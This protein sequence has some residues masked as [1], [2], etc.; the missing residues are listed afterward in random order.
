MSVLLTFIVSRAILVRMVAFE[1][2]QHLGLT[3]KE[4]SAYLA[5][6]EIGEGTVAAVA[7][8]SLLKRPTAYLILD[9]LSEKGFVSQFKRGKHTYYI[10]QNPKYL[11]SEAEM[12]LKEIREAIPQLETLFVKGKNKPRVLI[13]EGKEGADKAYDDWFITK[14][15]ALFLSSAELAQE[16]FEKT[17]RRVDF[18]T[19]SD[20][21]Y[22]RELILDTPEGREY[23]E[24]VRGQYRKVRFLPPEFSPFET[25]IGIY[26]NRVIITSIKQ[27]Y[28]AV[29]M[30][31]VSTADSFRKIYEALWRMSIE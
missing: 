3:P 30:E 7:Q 2:L 27:D 9:Q 8:K 24:K 17:Y 4:Q 1:P 16:V 5:L 25:D 22:F 18:K 19:L 23:G 10:A 14:G 31:S 13:F 28:F 6:L 11:V 29:V 26:G 12:R 20:E 15:E 21:F